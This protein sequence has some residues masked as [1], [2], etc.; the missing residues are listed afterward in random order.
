MFMDDVGRLWFGILV[1]LIATLVM[2]FFTMC[3]AAAIEFNDAKLK[4]MAEDNAKAQKL[5]KLLEAPSGLMNTSV[6]SR[7]TVMVLI[8]AFSA[9]YCYKPTARMLAE[10]FGGSHNYTAHIC[11]F[12]LLT[13][14]TAL[15][16]NVFGI[17]IPK[18]L[19]ASGK[20]GEKFILNTLWLYRLWL[21]IFKPLGFICDG[22][23]KAFLRIF[24][25][26]N[27]GKKNAIT[28]EEILLMVDAV[29]ESGA[30]EESQAEMISN[31][32]EFDDVEIR[33]VMTHR[34]E[35]LALEQNQSAADAVE[36]ALDKGISRIPVFE[37]SIDNIVGVVFVKDLLAFALEG[38][39]KE[40]KVSEY[41]RD[42][43]FV[44]ESNSC[45][46]VF[47]E[48]TDTKSQIAAVVDEYGGTAG[49]VTMEDLIET[50]VGSIQDEYDNEAEEITKLSEGV[51]DILGNAD[52]E[53]VFEQIGMDTEE[54]QDY[55]TIGGF[56]ID[57]LGYIPKEGQTPAVV[58]KDAKFK[59]LSAKDN[60]IIKLRATVSR[61]AE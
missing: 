29:G 23:S 44:P 50:I 40:H 16:V 9:V 7:G 53:D 24:G 20:V 36:L 39:A 27:Y 22:I 37:E 31:I 58:Y 43:Y 32:F 1:C 33:E 25:V 35:V 56:V 54:N 15:I 55:E 19:A 60:K 3:E 28:E 61:K 52:Y 13:L 11:S 5:Q 59:V 38:N 4:K 46:Q 45:K 42:I 47:K 41:T 21:G 57:L 49:I 18:K 8:S 26:K 12:L 17:T 30:I 14:I 6:V 48:F 10:I 34:T 51:F 2:G